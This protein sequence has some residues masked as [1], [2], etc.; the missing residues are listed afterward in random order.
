MAKR[1]RNAQSDE[2]QVEEV[3][4][5]ARASI[6]R[7]ACRWIADHEADVKAL[8]E[9]IAEYKQKHIKGDLGFKMADFNAI[10][11][12]SKLEVEDRDKLIDT[13]REGFRALGIGEQASFLGALDAAAG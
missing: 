7:D 13:L 3:D 4:A 8:R 1:L 12:V 6:I 11:R 5:G 10:Y 2:E 9:E